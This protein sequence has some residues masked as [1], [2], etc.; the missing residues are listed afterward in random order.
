MKNKALS[1]VLAC[2][3]PMLLLSYE[4]APAKDKEMVRNQDDELSYRLLEHGGRIVCNPAIRSSYHNRAT[5][6]SLWRQ[7][8]QYGSWKVRVLQKHPRRM[9]PSHFVPPTFAATLLSFALLAFVSDL[10]RLLLALV[11]G[12]YI[13]ANLAASVWT[14]RKSSWR[15]LLL[16]PIVFATLHLSYGLGFLTGLVRFAHRWRDR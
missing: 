14:A 8:F 4:A 5:L 3:I 16:L 6:G 10:G 1:I 11:F 7:Y 12:S 9:R 2:L 15:H 13:L